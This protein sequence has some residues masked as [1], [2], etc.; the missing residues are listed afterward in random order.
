[1]QVAKANDIKYAPTECH[2]EGDCA[3]TCPKC[4]ARQ[5]SKRGGILY[6]RKEGSKIFIAGNAVLYSVDELH[7]D[8]D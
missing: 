5:A 7:I 1:M 2:H 4:E 6:C 8:V 3:G